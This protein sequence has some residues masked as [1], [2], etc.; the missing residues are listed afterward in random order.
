ME[1]MTIFNEY[2]ISNILNK[3]GKVNCYKKIVSSEKANQYFGL[4]IQT[5]LWEK[6]VVI[7][8]GKHITTKRKVAWYG[9]SEYLYTYSNKTKRALAWTKELSELRQIV[10]ELAG[11]KLI[12]F[13]EL[14]S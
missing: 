12:L 10:E 11:I 14:I 8:F 1:Q 6:D 5:I 2:R 13:A 4:L 9:D 7:I 3:D